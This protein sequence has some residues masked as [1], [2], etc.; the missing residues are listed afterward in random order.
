MIVHCLLVIQGL[1]KKA[2]TTSL[3]ALV[4]ASSPFVVHL[5]TNFFSNIVLSDASMTSSSTP[6]A[7]CPRAAVS[8]QPPNGFKTEYHPRSGR[9]T[10]YQ[11]F[12][13]F[14]VTHDSEI[15]QA[16]VDEEPWRPFKSH[17]DFEF[18]EIALDAAL[19]KSQINALLGLISRISQGQ[20][21]VT[22]KNEADLSNA[23]D[24]AAAELTPV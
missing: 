15:Q 16:P 9:A 19:N 20:A 4:S 23:W 8:V 3:I 11:P 12:E 6:A 18:A 10:L 2:R 14:G 7:S 24:N 1:T 17:G 5:R 22:L 13:E 21:Q